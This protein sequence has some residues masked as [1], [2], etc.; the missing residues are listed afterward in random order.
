MNKLEPSNRTFLNILFFTFGI[1]ISFFYCFWG[2]DTTDSP[3]WYTMYVSDEKSHFM[4]FGTI[5]FMHFLTNFI[6]D[7]FLTYRVI[8]VIIYSISLL[9][10]FFTL[11]TKTTI[12]QTWGFIYFLGA[13][14][15]TSINFNIL[16]PDSFTILFI[17]LNY[18]LVNLFYRSNKPIYITLIAICIGFATAFRIP[19]IAILGLIAMSITLSD[20]SKYSKISLIGQV[21]LISMVTYGILFLLSHPNLDLYIDSSHNILITSS[22]QIN[23]IISSSFYSISILYITKHFVNN[24]SQPYLIG[25]VL[26]LFLLYNYRNNGGYNTGNSNLIWILIILPFTINAFEKQNINTNNI[27]FL[28][29]GVAILGSN[30]GLLKIS[31]GFIFLYPTIIR[32]QYLESKQTL[33]FTVLITFLLI[34]NKYLR[35]ETYEDD[36][37]TNIYTKVDKNKQPLSKKS[38]W[39]LSNKQSDST[40]IKNIA[41]IE[42]CKAPI[43]F[44]GENVHLYVYLYPKKVNKINAFWQNKISVDQL[45]HIQKMMKKFKYL[46]IPSNNSHFKHNDSILKPYYH[47]IELN[48]FNATYMNSQ[49]D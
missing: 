6:P 25:S 12:R 13:C 4:F 9:I 5:E 34:S 33:L 46:I 27:L 3:F 17:S 20:A 26:I 28:I 19:N 29:G 15:F 49:H 7:N 23:L 40:L 39:I 31:H 35:S 47:F 41:T 14:Y 16:S 36:R 44:Y 37:I 1:I 11:E 45:H 30:T 42:A 18:T 48:K 22:A 2:M 43:I 8:N 38:K 21:T 10:P 32:K 24:K